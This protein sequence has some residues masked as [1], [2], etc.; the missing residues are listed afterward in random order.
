MNLVVRTG[1]E[2]IM[3]QEQLDFILVPHTHWDREWYLTFQQFRIRLVRTVDQVLD[4]LDQDPAFTYFMLDGQT[5]VLED[6]LEVRPEQEERLKRHARSGRL[7]VGPWYLQPDEF[8]V[9]GESLIRNLMT[10]LRIAADYGG[11]MPVGYVPD[12]FGHIAQLP[13][14]LRGFGLDNA[15]FWR[16]VGDEARQSE[17]I[18]RAPDGSEVLVAHLAD[19]HGYS[20]ARS[21]P[22]D[23]DA[24]LRRLE[25]MKAALLPRA[26]TNT[27]LLMNGSDHLP[28]QAGLPAVIAAANA[29]LTG[30]HVR[31]GTLPQY[32]DALRAAP[33][34]R[35]IL[36]GEM[37]SS[38]RAPLLPGV[39]STRIW[40][41]QQ[42]AAGEHL[43]TGWAEPGCA[44]AWTLGAAYPAG[45]L[46]LAWK[47]LM[48]NHPH[49][50]IC[51]CSIDEVHR[52][53]VPRFAQSAQIAEEVTT[54]AL[55]TIAG[56]INTRMLVATAADTAPAPVAD[57]APHTPLP[58]TEQR[59]ALIVFNPAAGPRTDVA[60]TTVQLPPGLDEVEVVD[61]AGQP[62]SMYEIH[63]EVHELDSMMVD[64]DVVASTM[65]LIADGRIEGKAIADVT[66]KIS[67]QRGI[68][69]LEVTLAELAQPNMAIIRAAQ[70]QIEA[71]LA[72][73]DVTGFEVVLRQAPT[74]T[75]AF[76]ARD[77]PAHGYRTYAL[78]ARA[79]EESRALASFGR[80]GQRADTLRANAQIPVSGEE[81]AIEN[82]WFRVTV[83]V[84]SGTVTVFDKRTGTNY[85]GLN[86]FVDG[87]DV[88]D[89]YT[90]CPPLNDQLVSAPIEMPRVEVIER[91]E[92]RAV[93]RMQQVYALPACCSADR[94]S[95][96]EEM[97]LCAINSEITVAAGVEA[98]AIRTEVQNQ[99]CDHRLRVL[100][101]APF[102]TD[103]AIAEGT[104]M[105]HRRPVVLPQ[106]PG[107]H[108]YA[109]WAEE[110]VNTQP[111]KRFVD[112][113]DGRVGLAVLNKGLPEYEVISQSHG[114]MAIALT[115]LRCVGWLSRGD[116]RTRRGHAGPAKPT[117]EAQ[118]PGSHVFE[119]ALVPHPGDWQWD[120][121]AVQRLAEAFNMPLR[122]VVSDLHDGDL[123]VA[124]S[125]VTLTPRTLMISAIKHAEREEALVVRCYNPLAISQQAEL[126]LSTPFR[127]AVL[128]NLNEEPLADGQEAHIIARRDSD[129]RSAISFMMPAYSIRTILFRFG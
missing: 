56:R 104:F 118:C 100:F 42:N 57:N 105:V 45:L 90:Y 101:P 119:Y 98:I 4:I 20:N 59:L 126:V 31:I 117:P 15:V 41:K 81:P 111:H 84:P 1:F 26:T 127:E 36:T 49:D 64:K 123:P 43:L 75:L 11:A 5:I 121:A 29:Q 91:N 40:I 83:D 77:V 30:A 61:E 6:Y 69:R 103:H 53:M 99:A 94:Q 60:M 13:Q 35:Q 95:R 12:T 124:A 38:Q 70:Q 63:R 114:R 102:Q 96:S 55:Q 16:G 110:P 72:R 14:I 47:L 78:C 58:V 28:P 109:D 48:Q 88:G 128:V 27:L 76:Q 33:A 68:R 129:Q 32:L 92:V 65:A 116:L 93:L 97:V 37:R 2:V 82:A 51:G 50:S 89:L 66:I 39:L 74:I 3:Q 112:I 79:A 10:G 87:G 54:A 44:W 17:F 108:G 67:P 113:S 106:A 107:G 71:L 125:F 9:S 21:L 62:V 73:P 8:L 85:V 18:W 24:F 122:T 80:N 19:R 22:L 120:E 86:Q 52:E 25:M 46:R 34:E 115:L 23:V 7:L